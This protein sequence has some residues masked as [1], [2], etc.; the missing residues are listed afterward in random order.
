M[1]DL[2]DLNVDQAWMK[3]APNPAVR[4]RV[5]DDSLAHPEDPEACPLIEKVEVLE[6][7]EHKI[8]QALTHET[9]SGT[10]FSVV[11]EHPFYKLKPDGNGQYHCPYTSLEDCWYRPQKLK[12]KFQ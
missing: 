1:N 10:K 9:S 11:R 7:I 4:A 5:H 3:W 2:K 12:S 6:E 8:G